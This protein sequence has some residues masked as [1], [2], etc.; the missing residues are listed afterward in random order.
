MEPERA[1]RIWE[2]SVRKN[3]LRYT[4][5]QEDGDSKSFLAVKGTYMGTK[6]KKSECVGK[7]VRMCRTCS[8]TVGCRLRNF[9]K[10]VK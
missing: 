1:K 3:K 7:K 8:K 6:V 10:N 2:R 9:K 5:F 4:E